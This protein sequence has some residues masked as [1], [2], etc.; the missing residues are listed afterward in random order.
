MIV[1]VLAGLA[2]AFCGAAET[3]GGRE[4]FPGPSELKSDPSFGVLVDGTSISGNS[5]LI[6][7]TQTTFGEAIQE[8][9]PGL[10]QHGWYVAP[11]H[12]QTVGRATVLVAQRGDRCISYWNI[13]NG[14]Q[15]LG[16]RT[17]ALRENPNFAEEAER[18]RTVISVEVSG[19]G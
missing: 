5:L 19:C 18:Y 15:I 17:E 8:F 10:E 9:I 11:E 12:S 1:L 13:S 7:G 6:L 16:F 14:S 3:K 2:S 4:R